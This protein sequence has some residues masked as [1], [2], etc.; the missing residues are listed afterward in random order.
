M[1]WMADMIGLPEDFHFKGTGGGCIQVNLPI[2][3]SNLQGSA[4]EAI[5]VSLVAA[6]R[7]IED[8]LQKEGNLP[9][10]SIFAKLMMYCSD[11]V[12]YYPF[13]PNYRLIL[14]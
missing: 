9:E 3:E 12:L 7:R 5:L 13:Q 2:S 1:D 14:L 11:Q 8:K 4:S 6:R 10:E